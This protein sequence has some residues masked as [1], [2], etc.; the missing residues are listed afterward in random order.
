MTMQAKL[1]DPNA[2]QKAV[3]AT[4]DRVASGK[5][6]ALFSHLI[7]IM[8]ISSI[9]VKDEFSPT[10]AQMHELI[11]PVDLVWRAREIVREAMRVSNNEGWTVETDDIDSIYE[12]AARGVTGFR[13]AV[14]ATKPL[15]VNDI[16]F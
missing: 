15:L 9:P 7:G 13:D 5:E 11:D 4:H 2:T 14:Q 1:V 8:A 12:E 10:G 16:P 6:F 3:V